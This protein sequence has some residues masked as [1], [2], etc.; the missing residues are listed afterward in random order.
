MEKKTSKSLKVLLIGQ[1]FASVINSLAIGFDQ[2][3]GVNARAISLDGL[4]SEYNS[5]SNYFYKTKH[6]SKSKIPYALSKI[7]G[8]IVL[9]YLLCWCD[10]VHVFFL[11]SDTRFK[12]FERRLVNFF[13]KRHVVT[14]MGSEVRDPAISS[15][16]NL[17][18]QET[19]CH[20]NY[21]YKN[22]SS[23]LSQSFQ[24]LYSKDNYKLIVWDIEQYID[25]ALFKDIRI[26]PH[27]SSNMLASEI[28]LKDE[29]FLVVH[30]PSAP[31][32][33]GTAIIQA[34]MNKIIAKYPY[35]KFKILKGIS[36]MEYQRYLAK[37]DIL[38]DQMIWGGYGIAAQQAME[39]GKVVCTYINDSRK[40]LY[41]SNCPVININKE[42][43]YSEIE[44]LILDNEYMDKVK[45]ASM[46]YYQNTHSPINVAKQM[47]DAYLSFFYGN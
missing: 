20:P 45:K 11:T 4:I 17:Y 38:I 46:D 44:K 36:I 3:E 15:K 43:L 19:F 31:I 23:A 7:I 5:Y 10:V 1:N 6:S 26:V 28:S 9:I 14:F 39:M 12:N 16:E 32:A 27:A 34:G 2:I 37:S 42:T 40:I 21:E 18:Y 13:C 22:E 30:S 8:I 47:K 29:S 25:K 35:V 33:K 41:G 24:K